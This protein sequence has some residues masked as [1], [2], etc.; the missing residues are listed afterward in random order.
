MD[1]SFGLT[2]PQQW[3]LLVGIVFI[4][5]ALISVFMLFVYD[6]FTERANWTERLR[7][8]K[9]PYNTERYTRR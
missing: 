2:G 4:L 6:R 5:T 3:A 8:L 1:L 9:Q 7:E